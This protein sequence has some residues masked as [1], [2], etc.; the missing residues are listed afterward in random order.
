[1]KEFWR[2]YSPCASSDVAGK[3]ISVGIES[4]YCQY[5]RHFQG[6]SPASTGLSRL[7]FILLLMC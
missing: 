2:L 1:M 3:I 6:S 7:M 5:L 4:I